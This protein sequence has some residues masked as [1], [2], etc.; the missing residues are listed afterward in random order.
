ME[1]EGVFRVIV[2]EKKNQEKRC[3]QPKPGKNCKCWAVC[4]IGLFFDLWIIPDD[5]GWIKIENFFECSEFEIKK[6]ILKM[7]ISGAYELDECWHW[8]RENKTSW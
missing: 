5:R 4:F 7:F 2:G 6:Y 1:K 3:N 8:I